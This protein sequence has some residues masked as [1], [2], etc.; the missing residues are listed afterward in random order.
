MTT[1]RRSGAS[2]T[3]VC[4]CPTT[5]RDLADGIGPAPALRAAGSPLCLGSDS[6]A[7]IDLF[8]EARGLEMHARLAAGR[9]GVLEPSAL[10][11]ALTV[12]G[13]RAI[14]WPEAAGWQSVRRPTWSPS[15]TDTVRTVG[16]TAE[17][18]VMAATAA[19]VDTVVVG[20]EMVVRAGRHRL[21][22]V[23]ALLAE[24]LDEIRAAVDEQGAP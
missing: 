2:G 15:R 9:R 8:E 19:D 11:R 24:A 7:V 4:L 5:E 20:G 13:H 18:L 22:D 23:A 3:S 21:G 10:V 16:A 1:S 6:H 14:G 12:D 17:Q